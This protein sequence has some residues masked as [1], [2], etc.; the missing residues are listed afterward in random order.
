MVKKRKFKILCI[1]ITLFLLT[2]ILSV[3]ATPVEFGERKIN[4]EGYIIHDYL[5][6]HNIEDYDVYIYSNEREL[7]D[8]EFNEIFINT[9]AE[10]PDNPTRCNHPNVNLK[11][12]GIHTSSYS[13]CNKLICSRQATCTGCGYEWIVPVEEPNGKSHSF[14]AWIYIETIIQGYKIY[15]VY[16]RYCKNS[17]G[18]GPCF[19]IET[20]WVYIGDI[21][22]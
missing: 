16:D 8:A 17:T 10:R 5:C 7:L 6:G 4:E 11:C 3:S 2:S 18:F 21:M 13:V 22:K 1:L 15:D 9:F 20:K 19:T 14:G 12:I